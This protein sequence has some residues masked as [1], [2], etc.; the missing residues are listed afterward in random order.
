VG[1]QAVAGSWTPYIYLLV[2]VDL[3]IPQVVVQASHAAIEAARLFLSTSAEH[4]HLVLCRM[5][6]EQRLLASA[7]F[8]VRINIR[9]SLFREPDRDGQATA[10]ATE[11]LHGEQ[12]RLMNRFHC[13]QSEDF[14]S[15]WRAGQT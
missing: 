6:S 12:R 3:S 14:P 8:L 4:P 10:L 1:F 9:F 13:L 7:D 2:R 15:L 11:P 5:P